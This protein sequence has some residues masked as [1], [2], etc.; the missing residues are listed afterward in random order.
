MKKIIQGIIFLL[1][2]FF[3]VYVILKI[4]FVDVYRILKTLQPKFFLLAFSALSLSFVVISV[5][6]MFSLRNFSEPHFWFFLKNTLAGAFI[7]TI[8]PGAQVGGEPVKAYFIGKRY[9]KSKTRVFGA[10]LVDRAFH[11]LASVFF[12]VASLLFILTQIPVSYE[13][14]IIF[15]T[16]L[17]FIF[18]LFAIIVF[19]SLKKGRFTLK[20]L[21]KKLENFAHLKKSKK[22]KTFSK[23]FG[24]LAQ[25]F[26]KT[27][28]DKKT[29]FIGLLFSAIYW[30]L[31]YLVS[32]F[33]FLSLEV[34]VSLF[35]VIV[36]VSL[37]SLVGD[38]SPGP[39][40]IGLVEGFMIFVYSAIGIDFSSAV[41]VALLS[42]LILYFHSLILGGLSFWNL[43]RS[44]K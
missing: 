29:L 42:R 35:L 38:F 41:I 13:L 2:L 30:I 40:G 31:T 43:E 22:F 39:G 8:T 33:L 17:F 36:V 32:Y 7:N 6:T 26:K 5:R 24:N 3:I 16:I 37:G 27:L 11:A 12:I 44:M 28:S 21:F 1:F 34:R 10:I 9:N 14:R 23:G 25:T 15:Q 20:Y 19:L 18:L 4:D